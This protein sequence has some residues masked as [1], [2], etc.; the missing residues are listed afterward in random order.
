M[1]AHDLT[2]E[3]DT[4][5]AAA[6][7][8][9]AVHD[10]KTHGNWARGGAAEGVPGG[11]V[12][13]GRWVPGSVPPGFNDIGKKSW[14]DGLKA[15]EDHPEWFNTQVIAEDG[16]PVAVAENDRNGF[17]G[18]GLTDAYYAASKEQGYTEE[19]SGAQTIGRRITE[20]WEAS[21]AHAISMN[22]IDAGRAFIDDYSHSKG[23][24]EKQSPA[25]QRWGYKAQPER[26]NWDEL[27]EELY[28][29]TSA[30]EAV[31]AT[32]LKTRSELE[33]TAG[34][35]GGTDAAISFTGDRKIVEAIVTGMHELRR[36]VRDDTGPAYVEEMKAEAK[37]WSWD[38]TSSVT[39]ESQFG[40]QKKIEDSRD[41]ADIYQTFSSWREHFTKQPDP[42]FFSVN[43]EA[44][45]NLDPSQ[46][47][48]VTV[49]PA[50][51]GAKGW[52]MSALGE[53]RVATGDAV[54]VMSIEIRDG[55]G[56]GYILDGTDQERRA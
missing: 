36:A 50:V 46:I 33:N 55:D 9:H 47:G 28:H 23:E 8:K 39:Y 31:L 26:G 10:Q 45:A 15:F 24:T 49:R 16:L 43:P 22:E 37:T 30:A 27:P 13:D 20:E 41:R 14:A 52:Q 5:L 53:W 3:L 4:N 29:V 21:I 2:E 51:T 42:L 34:L 25:F 18:P 11:S 38:P 40:D 6:L 35:G 44:F 56:D 12:V 48:V 54:E 7:S 32:G 17:R 19:L 1:K